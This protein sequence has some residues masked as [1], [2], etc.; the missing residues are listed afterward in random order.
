MSRRRPPAAVVVTALATAATLAA[1]TAPATAG[2][3][4]VTGTLD[5]LRSISGTGT[6]AGQHNKE[7]NSDPARW[8]RRVHEITGD[9]PGL[10]GGDF[11]FAQDDVDNRPTMVDQ[12]VNE[13]ANG[14]VVTLTWHVCP[15]TQGTS[16]T[17]EDGVT[18]SLSEEQWGELM[19]D[20]SPLNQAWK[21]RLD[22]AVPYLRELRDAGVQVLWRPLHEMNE[23]WS[24]WGGRPGPEGSA[25]LY[26]ITHDY[27]TGRQGLDNLIW[28]WNVKDVEI[29]SIGD[30]WPGDELVDV[31]SLDIWAKDEPSTED[32]EAMRAV[33]GDRPIALGEVGR[34]PRP[35]TLDAQPLWTY[36]MVWAEYLDTTEPAE[37]QRTYWDDRVLVLDELDRGD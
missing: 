35:E 16:C 23:G 2:D 18:S 21:A 28:N 27:L 14:A 36:F 9:H 1:G 25:G 33:A 15:P 12:A 11:L 19:T 24:W 34:V 6:I 17:W 4:S 30:Y 7:P 22:E 5:Y 8:T 13:W 29:G 26:R 32:Y 31:A 10:W 20:G 3:P 37:L